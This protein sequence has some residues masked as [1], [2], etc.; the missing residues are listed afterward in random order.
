MN[1]HSKKM[2]QLEP[3]NEVLVRL[4]LGQHVVEM[5]RDE[6]FLLMFMDSLQGL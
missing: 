4:I 6:N 2:I 3:S 5:R 1:Y